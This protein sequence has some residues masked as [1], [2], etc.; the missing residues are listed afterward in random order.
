ME[1]SSSTYLIT[2]PNRGSSKK[3]RWTYSYLTRLLGI[4]HGLLRHYLSRPNTTCIAA[5]RD[6]S[7]SKLSEGLLPTGAGSKLIVVKIDSSV[8]TDAQKAF[9][10]LQGTYGIKKIDVVC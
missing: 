3:Q 2:G 9:E 1:S 5:V 10:K 6:P 8:A 4:G 7:I